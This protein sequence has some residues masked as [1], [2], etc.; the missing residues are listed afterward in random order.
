MIRK[1]LAVLAGFALWTVLWLASNQLA[2][3]LF[4]TRF[5]ERGMTDDAGLLAAFVVLSALF[6]IAAG[7]T[8]TAVS[9]AG[10][11]VLALVLGALLLAVGVLVQ[12]TVW[13]QMP[14]WFHLS[15]LALLVPASAVG[16]RLHN[17]S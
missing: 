1:L 15:F 5:D 12:S 8:T 14:L 11:S 16:A 13:D 10:S 7:W 6:S 2:L 9:R 3:R 4:S 17:S